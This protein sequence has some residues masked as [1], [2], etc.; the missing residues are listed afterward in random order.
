MNVSEL[1]AKFFTDDRHHQVRMEAINME[2]NQRILDIMLKHQPLTY[3]QTNDGYVGQVKS[4]NY[5]DATVMVQRSDNTIAR[6][7]VDEL[8]ITADLARIIACD[9][10]RLFS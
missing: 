2:Y 4:G 3:V 6:Y 7:H 1:K 10:Q 5:Y 9:L 8:K